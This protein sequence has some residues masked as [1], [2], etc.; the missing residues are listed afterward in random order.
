MKYS[1]KQILDTRLWKTIFSITTVMLLSITML[2]GQD[3]K[4]AD[5]S[6]DKK[7]V[8]ATF[9]SAEL[10]DVQSVM[11]PTA[12][13]LTFNIQHRFGTV[14]NGFTDLYGVYAPANIRMA[15][16][17]TPINNLAVGF[18]YTKFNRYLDLNAK[19]S[20]LKQTRDGGM[21]VSVT[22]FGNVAADTRTDANYAK[23]VYKLSYYAELIIASKLS[24][25]ISLQV[26]PSF[27]HFN[28]VDSLYKN[29]VIAVALAGRYKLSPQSSLMV[30]YV[31]QLTKYPVN[32]N[33]TLK[34]GVTIGW[35]IATSAHAFQIFFTNF[36]GIV[37][38]ENIARN[39]FDFFK[40]EFLLGFN[41]T[42]LW[43]F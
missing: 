18:G 26:T 27:S 36:Q 8:K 42:R 20:I 4:A 30:T 5:A 25:K 19:Y 35:E 15:F 29:D 39:S 21:P 22:F 13:T 17:Y 11:V 41:I 23:S 28:A 6:S 31:Q 12:K 33:F 1:Q 38:Q 16:N 9:E 32:K 43:N 37:P 3:E 14:Q 10:M 40:G 24:S 2:Q 34:P 7:P